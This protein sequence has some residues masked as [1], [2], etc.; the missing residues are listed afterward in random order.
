MWHWSHR[1][2][3]TV[4]EAMNAMIKADYRICEIRLKRLAVFQD[5]ITSGMGVSEYAPKSEAARNVTALYTELMK[6]IK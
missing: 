2:Y 3:R 5:A 4:T 1:L 6:L